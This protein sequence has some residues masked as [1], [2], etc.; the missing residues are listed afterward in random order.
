MLFSNQVFYVICIR[1]V[2]I[3]IFGYIFHRLKAQYVAIKLIA[4]WIHVVY[5]GKLD[6]DRPYQFAG[7]KV[8]IY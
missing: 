8:N 3:I 5:D 7:Q 6:P 1:N 2:V 4:F